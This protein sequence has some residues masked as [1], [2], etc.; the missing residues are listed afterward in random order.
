MR[1]LSVTCTAAAFAATAL[2]AWGAPAPR[3]DAGSETSGEGRTPLATLLAQVQPRIPPRVVIFK[4]RRELQVVVGA[5]VLRSYSCVFGQSPLEE[6][7]REGDHRTPTGLY[8]ICNKNPRS[9]YHLFLGLSY[10]S[11]ADA[12]RGL[13][14]ARITGAQ[15]A[16]IASAEERRR[17]S[18]WPARLWYT[19]L[20]GEV[21][22][23]GLPGK[24]D[25]TAL[26]YDVQRAGDWTWGC[27]SLLNRDIEELFAALPVGTEVELRR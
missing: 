21:G 14:E 2:L 5:R 4:G 23:H 10:P 18:D 7:C 11:S 22:I 15:A 26:G 3:A 17:F 9:R 19:P 1:W 13:Q 25:D 8:Y 27:I 6:K 24:N 12:R 20:G 16:A